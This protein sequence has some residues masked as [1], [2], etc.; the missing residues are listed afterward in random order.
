MHDL[1]ICSDGLP[2][3]FSWESRFKRS[4]TQTLDLSLQQANVCLQ[5][6]SEW[7]RRF[8]DTQWHSHPLLPVMRES[9][10]QPTETTL[11]NGAEIS[12]LGACPTPLRRS[13]HCH[14]KSRSR[15]K[16]L[17]KSVTKK[18]TPKSGSRHKPES[19]LR[20]WQH[21]E[22]AWIPGCTWRFP[23]QKARECWLRLG[24]C[25]ANQS[26]LQGPV[27][28]LDLA[29]SSLCHYSYCSSNPCILLVSHKELCLQLPGHSVLFPSSGLLVCFLLPLRSSLLCL[30]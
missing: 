26:C 9:V 19:A 7:E 20:L 8:T 1:V 22:Q 27:F 12:N 2:V 16:E 10:L 29:P 11:R 23:L 17:G 3:D 28:L 15:D 13:W 5:Q 24:L 14:N 25:K 21:E 4:Q 6:L 30:I 18:A